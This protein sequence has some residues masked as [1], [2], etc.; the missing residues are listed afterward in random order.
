MEI[1]K[2]KKVI[3]KE[4]ILRHTMEISDTMD[5]LEIE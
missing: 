1:V 2:D 4:T 3:I 5:T